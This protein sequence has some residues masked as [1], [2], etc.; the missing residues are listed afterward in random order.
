MVLY[1]KNKEDTNKHPEWDSAKGLREPIKALEVRF[2][3]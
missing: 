3:D 1:N 2:Y